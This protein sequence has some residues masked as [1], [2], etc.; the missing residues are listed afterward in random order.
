MP[1][2][3]DQ[4]VHSGQFD[5]TK[6]H[7]RMRPRK[8]SLDIG[9]SK[10]E[11]QRIQEFLELEREQTFWQA[12]QDLPRTAICILAIFAFVLIAIV[13]VSKQQDAMEAL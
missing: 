6:S 13:S 7:K 10:Q 5:R 8:L 2:V 11:Q 3:L 9:P 1:L 4:V 12:Y